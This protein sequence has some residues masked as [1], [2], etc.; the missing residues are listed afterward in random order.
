MED[1]ATPQA[2]VHNP[3]RKPWWMVLPLLVL[4]GTTFLVYHNVVRSGILITLHFPHGQGLETGSE[5]RYQGIAVGQVES[6]S[7]N[8][9]QEGVVVRLRLEPSAKHLAREGS[10][11]WVVRP[12]ISSSRI[13][14]LDTLIGAR[15]LSVIPGKGPAQNAFKGLA[16]A[17]VMADLEPGGLEITL[18]ANQLGSLQAGAPIRYRQVEVGRVLSIALAR[19]ASAV[20]VR[21]YIEP[22]YRALIR[23]NTTFWNTSGIRARLGVTGASL[24]IDSLSSI[25]RGGISLATPTQAGEQVVTGHQFT[26]HDERHEDWLTWRPSLSVGEPL[27]KHLYPLPVPVR[28]ELQWAY[29]GWTGTRLLSNSAWVLLSDKGLIGLK[30]VLTKPAE[31]DGQTPTLSV[32]GESFAII[33]P[34]SSETDHL[35]L[36]PMVPAGKPWPFQRIRAATSPEDVLLIADSNKQPQLV[37]SSRFTTQAATWILDSELNKEADWHG[38]LAISVADGKLIGFL[39]CQE[40]P[41]KIYPIQPELLPL[42]K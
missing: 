21:A 33:K 40:S 14:G 15:Y 16:K 26:L 24:E 4:I 36:L 25:I 18:H 10:L 7:L 13:E 42:A 35:A 30:S 19:D 17:P 27:P 29:K 1:N 6:L 22:S 38:A 32:K 28:S 20:V 12:H 31:A 41:Q 3:S 39:D 2:T 11:F 37:S 23:K 9:H 34:P 5:L 8:N